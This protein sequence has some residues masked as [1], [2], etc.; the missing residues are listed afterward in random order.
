MKARVRTTGLSRASRWYLQT[1]K[2]RALV[3]LLL[4]EATQQVRGCGL[5]CVHDF[6]EEVGAAPGDGVAPRVAR[7]DAEGR[8]L[9]RHRRGQ[10]Q[11]RRLAA[12]QTH[13]HTDRGTEHRVDIGY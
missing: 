2:K 3:R 1:T 11:A 9:A 13:L 6:D 12:D 7:S 8:A 4:S 5:A 10:A